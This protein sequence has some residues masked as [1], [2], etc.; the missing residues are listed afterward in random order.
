[1]C[2]ELPLARMERLAPGLCDRDGAVS[3]D[4]RFGRDEQGRNLA[5]GPV[6]ARL[7]VPC[8]RCMECMEMAVAAAL[9][10]VFGDPGGDEGAVPEG[11]ESVP[12]ANGRIS[13]LE[14]I[15]DELILALPMAPVHEDCPGGVWRRY[16]G[17]EAPSEGPPRPFAALSRLRR[18]AG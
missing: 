16:M 6:T 4:L 5:L 15:E 11:H 7:R 12:L 1:M 17:G 8:Q 18:S 3:I 14:L 13:L 2:G 10:L 9:R